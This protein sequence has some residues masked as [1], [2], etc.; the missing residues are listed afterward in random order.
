MSTF[1]PASKSLL[2][3][4]YA[5][6]TLISYQSC[7]PIRASQ[8]VYPIFIHSDSDHYSEILSLPGQ[9]R[10][11]V[12]NI[13]K[14][15]KPLVS[16]GLKSVLIFGVLSDKINKDENADCALSENSPVVAALKYLRLNYPNLLIM[17]DVCL[18]AYTSHGHCGILNN[19]G[20]INNQASIERLAEIA[21]YYADN[22]CHVVLSIIKLLNYIQVAPS[23]MMDG[24]IGAIASKTNATIMSYSSK[25]QS[26]LYGANF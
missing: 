9:Y 16:I 24:R 6:P 3:G 17:C 11:G 26:C 8:L 13:D 21:K 18:C 19:D 5:H 23:D 22:G 10:V 4:G 12:N 1:K 15:I 7:D 20:T 14:I 25:F 2:H